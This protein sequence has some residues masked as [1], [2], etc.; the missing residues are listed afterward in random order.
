MNILLLGAN[1]FGKVHAKSYKNLGYDFS[2]YDRNDSVLQEYRENYDVTATYSE[3]D[4]ALNSSYDAI[5][6][7]L[8]HNLHHDIA[9]RAIK[10]RKHVLMEKPIS[11]NLDEARELISTSKKYD[12]K[13]MIAE[14]YFFDSGLRETLRLISQGKIGKLHSIIVRDQ[15]FYSKKNWR[16]SEKIMGGGA[17]IDG[18]IHYIETLLDLGGR[19]EEIHSYNYKGG[20]SLEGEDST[21]ALF[22]FENDL[23]GILYYSWGYNNAPLLP[24]YEVVGSEGSIVEDVKTKPG[25]D[26]KEQKPPRHAFGLPALNGVVSGAEIKDV[27][28]AEISGF[29][30]AIEKDTDVPYSSEF[31]VRNLE[32]VLKIYRNRA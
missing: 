6:I 16:S 5:D 30:N 7:V 32:T 20:S 24:S 11:T 22:K 8:P 28:D 29:L 3:M 14:Q 15:R 26:F 1:G 13:F 31:A 21:A 4:S 18:G 25:H 9:L 12:I 23:H 10:Q 2:V 17:L 19:Y 27:F